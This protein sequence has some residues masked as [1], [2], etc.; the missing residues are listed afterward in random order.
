MIRDRRKGG[1]RRSVIR[2]EVAIDI[3]WEGSKGRETGVLGDISE[4]GCFVLGSG[5]VEDGDVVRLFV[6]ISDGMKVE[7]PGEVVN[8]V[9]E[10]GFGM[11]FLG[12]NSAQEDVVRGLIAAAEAGR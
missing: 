8:H 10:I 9:I 3:E 4:V 6:P 1:E 7:F 11:K 5:E 2:H 12:L